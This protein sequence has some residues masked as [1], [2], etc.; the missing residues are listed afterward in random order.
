MK[1][2]KAKGTRSKGSKTAGEKGKRG[3]GKRNVNGPMGFFES[4]APWALNLEPFRFPLALSR[5]AVSSEV[6][7]AITKAELVSIVGDKC[8]FSR[9]ESAQIIEQVFQILKETLEKGEKVKISGFGNFVI[10]EKRPRRG[11][12]PQSGEEMMISGRRVLTFKP[13]AILRKA[14]N[15]ENHGPAAIEIQEF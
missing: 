6:S 1:R 11:R 13:S 8:S 2:L 15:G 14:V 10:R 4:L 9:L 5:L 12:N 7:L 3:K